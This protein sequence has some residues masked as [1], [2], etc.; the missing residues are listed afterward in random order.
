MPARYRTNNSE[1]SDTEG[2]LVNNA[3]TLENEKVLPINDPDAKDPNNIKEARNSGYWDL[4][5]AAIHKELGA[6]KAK[7]IYEVINELTP[8]RCT[9]GS[10][11][12]LHM[13]RDELG[14]IGRFKARLVA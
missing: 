8:H 12:V 3:L 1:Y 4:W 9:V 2:W 5:L 13:K 10:K 11:W 14:W 7:G 6:L